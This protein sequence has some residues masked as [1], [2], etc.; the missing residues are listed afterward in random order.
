[1]EFRLIV[2]GPDSVANTVNERHKVALTLYHNQSSFLL[3]I[4]NTSF[5]ASW[6]KQT[7]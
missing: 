6:S 3:K 7:I 1:M 2:T 5:E 4:C